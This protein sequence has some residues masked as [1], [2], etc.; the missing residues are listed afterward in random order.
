M[1]R[2][3]HWS[4]AIVGMGFLGGC[5]SQLPPSQVHSVAYYAARIPPPPVSPTIP[6]APTQSV[7]PQNVT[8]H[9]VVNTEQR[10]LYLY[11]GPTLLATYPVA[12]GFGGSAPRRIRGDDKTPVGHYHIGY[13]RWG[14]QY[15]PFM[16]LTYPNRRDAEWGLR[17]GVITQSQY[18]AIVYAID[19]GQV[20]PQNTPLGGYIGIHGM[21]PGFSYSRSATVFPGRWTAGCVALSNHDAQNLAGIVEPGT[22]VEIVG[23]VGSYGQQIGES[24]RLA[25]QYRHV[26][27]SGLGPSTST[28]RD[29]VQKP[30]TE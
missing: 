15:G 6:A 2:W 22:P 3:Y 7:A 17:E 14:T 11:R 9:I 23:K 13:V 24:R 4:L 29:V 20:P 16:L 21:G 8:L 30:Q 5:T 26:A 18:Q 27:D 25:F 19:N 28:D 10:K 12:I 1:G